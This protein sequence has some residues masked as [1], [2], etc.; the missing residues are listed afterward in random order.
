MSVSW[1]AEPFLIPGPKKGGEKPKKTEQADT[2]LR[3]FAPRFCEVMAKH[4]LI[5]KWLYAKIPGWGMKELFLLFIF[6]FS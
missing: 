3:R 2:V 1:R 6:D 5:L 4:G